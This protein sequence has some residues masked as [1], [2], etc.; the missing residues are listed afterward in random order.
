MDLHGFTELVDAWIVQGAQ[1]STGLFSIICS[2]QETSDLLNVFLNLPRKAC[3]SRFAAIV[4]RVMVQ[5]RGGSH[6]ADPCKLLRTL[7]RNFCVSTTCHLNP[8]D[9]CQLCLVKVL[10]AAEEWQ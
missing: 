9:S 8:F 5:A 4:L 7:R 3:D 1:I 6:L 2:A 10:P